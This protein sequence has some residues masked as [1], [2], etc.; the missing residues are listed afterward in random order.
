MKVKTKSYEDEISYLHRLE[1]RY[2]CLMKQSF[3]AAI[4]DRNYSDEL[5]DIALKIKDEI[6]SLRINLY[7]R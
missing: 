5:N 7:A 2:S 3:E 1:K 4:K 6:K